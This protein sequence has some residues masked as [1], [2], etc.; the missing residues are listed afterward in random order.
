[1]F[2][3]PRQA[4]YKSDGSQVAPYGPFLM[5]ITREDKECS[6]LE[7][8]GLVVHT[9]MEQCGQFMGG[10]ARV[11]GER[12]PLS[13]TYGN[14]G[15]TR[16]VSQKVWEMGT[17]IPPALYDAWNKGG[18]WNSAGSEGPAM[19]DWGISLYQS[20]KRLHWWVGLIDGR[21]EAFRS[22]PEAINERGCP[23]KAVVG[24]F[25]T[26]LGCHFMAENELGN[27]R[28]VTVADAERLA[29]RYI[30]RMV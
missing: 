4:R 30:M 14:D 22:A 29:K 28:C 19:L 6:A 9:K 2:L 25:R 20:K 10:S 21:M 16:D 8:R 1:M 24:P 17:P 23:Y 13:G 5:L 11:L 12:I 7:V 18:G 27:P 3:T 26:K 15:L